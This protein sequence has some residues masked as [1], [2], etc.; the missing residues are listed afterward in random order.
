MAEIEPHHRQLLQPYT[1]WLVLRRLRQRSRTRGVTDSSVSYARD[2]AR[3][4]LNFLRWLEE[5]GTTLGQAG[6]HDVDQW[7]TQGSTTRRRLRDFL[8]WTWRCGLSQQLIVPLLPNGQAEHFIDEDHHVELLHVCVQDDT[9]PS[10]VRA[11]GALLLLFGVK[12]T[13]IARLARQDLTRTGDQAFITFGDH[14]TPLPPAVER[15]LAAQAA[16][17]P[18]TLSH[19]GDPS[20]VPW[21]FP[22]AL[23]GRPIAAHRLGERLAAHG[24]DVRPTRNTALLALAE[25][26]P[27]PVISD[28]LDLHIN[29]A[30]Y[31]SKRGVR[32]WSDYVAGRG[33]APRSGGDV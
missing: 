15:L 7:L 9:L 6:Q 31:W 17:R 32:D 12:V 21:L 5:R 11:A 1:T 23:P 16:R 14:P 3:S 4:A 33:T 2:Q 26:L 30:V 27:A 13:R 8:R 24:I 22:G 29:T 28:L 20:S 10:D 18:R 19:H 25:D